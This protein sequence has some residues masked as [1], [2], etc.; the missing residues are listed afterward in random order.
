LGATYTDG[1]AAGFVAGFAVEIVDAAAFF[2]QK[3]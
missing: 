3:K 1:L 2:G